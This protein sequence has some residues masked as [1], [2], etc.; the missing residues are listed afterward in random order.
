M[1]VAT[2]E[3]IRIELLLGQARLLDDLSSSVLAAIAGTGGGKTALGYWWVH[4]RME[5]YPGNTW[6][7]AEPT[8]GLLEKVIIT[9]SDP[10]R[11]SLEQYLA[12]AGH[13]PKWLNKQQ[14]ILG[15]DWGQ[16]YLGSA[17][18]PDSMQGA[19]LKGYWLDEP[20][21]MRLAA[22]QTAMQRVS[23]MQG[24][25]LLTTTPYNLGWLKTE[26]ADQSGTKGIHV[27]SWRS[28]DRPG[29]PVQAYEE[30][31]RKL[32]P[33]RFAM[34][35]DARFEHPAGLIYGAFNESTCLID[36]FEI[37]KTWL[38]YAG[39]DFGASNPAAVFYAQDPTT[40]LLWA[41]HEY[42]PGPGK[43]VY[44]HVQEFKKITQGYSVIARVGGSHQEEEVRQAYT[45]QG[46]HIQE[47][48]NNDVETQI[49]SVI[50]VH[51]LNKLKVFR[52]MRNYLDEKRTYS[53]K[54]GPDSFPTDEIEDKAKSH[55]MDAERYILSYFRPDTVV[56]NKTSTKRS[57]YRF[58]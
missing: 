22:Y 39:H 48:N 11:P 31:K 23:M 46:W 17:D 32:P 55:L 1:A 54:I 34:L 6:G 3:P 8:F 40:G 18:N 2:L 53:R 29:F 14:L 50:G 13:H 30:M 41:F 5:R 21:L 45:A 57:A 56:N 9:S 12:G 58:N 33:W 43:S 19:A 26:V 15:T 27:E 38:I 36:R 42:L 10:N 7:I 51:Q 49:L 37:P 52:D 47:P 24:Q 35:Y 44:E 20:G 16:I 25:I 28:I 4:S